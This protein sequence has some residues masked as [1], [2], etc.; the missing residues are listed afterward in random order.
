ML[1]EELLKKG[2]TI[3]VIDPHADY[4][5][6]SQDQEENHIE[7]YADRIVVFRNPTAQEDIVKRHR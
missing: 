7:E 2:A 3:V 1:L 5:F 4:V 6:L